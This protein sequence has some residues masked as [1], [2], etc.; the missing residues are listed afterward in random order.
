MHWGPPEDVE[1]YV[2][3]TGRADRDGK[4]SHVIMLFSKGLERH[5]DES[6]VKYCTNQDKCCR[7]TLFCDFDDFNSTNSGY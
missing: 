5:V 3:A 7:S 2:Q 4:I 6:M 1:Q